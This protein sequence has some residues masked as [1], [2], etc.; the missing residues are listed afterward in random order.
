MKISKLFENRFFPVSS[1]SIL[2]KGMEIIRS[3][4]APKNG[5]AVMALVVRRNAAGEFVAV[6]LREPL[7]AGR[8]LWADQQVGALTFPKGLANPGERPSDAIRREIAEEL[9]LEVLQILQP[10]IPALWGLPGFAAHRTTLFV[11]L[12][13]DE[14]SQ[15]PEGDDDELLEVVEIP[16]EQLLS[17]PEREVDGDA[18]HIAAAT[19]PRALKC[20]VAVGVPKSLIHRVLWRRYGDLL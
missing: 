19:L 6:C 4:W 14:L 2:H 20:L 8:S 1:V 17:Q 10:N 7:Q 15:A 9:G 12:V 18:R 13:G 5:N 11:V 16:L 3:A